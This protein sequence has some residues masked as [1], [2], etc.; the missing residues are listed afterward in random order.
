MMMTILSG[1]VI[2]RGLK[3]AAGVMRPNH[4]G[5]QARRQHV[6]VRVQA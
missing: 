1:Q 4:L 2:Q 3:R 6:E 5:G